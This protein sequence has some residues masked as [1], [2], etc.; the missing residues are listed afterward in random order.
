MTI[1]I[2]DCC[3]KPVGKDY[4]DEVERREFYVVRMENCDHLDLCKTCYASI[5]NEIYRLQTCREEPK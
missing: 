3:K 2:C 1:K 5:V 4:D